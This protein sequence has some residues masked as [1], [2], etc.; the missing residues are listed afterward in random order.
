MRI[1]VVGTGIS[2]N[3]LAHELCREHEVTVFEARDRPGGHTDTWEVELAGR[4]YAVDT[5]FIVFNDRT[6]PG[7]CALLERLGV[8]SRPTTMSFGV[9]CEASGLEYCGSSLGGLFAQPANLLRPRF[10]R[11]LLDILR[12][13]RA[14]SRLLRAEAGG[15]ALAGAPVTAPVLAAGGP[16]L[17]EFLRQGGY[18]AGFAEHYFLPMA[19]AI[20]SA[21]AADIRRMPLGFLLRFFHN[22]GLLGIAGRPQW[23]TVEG[24]SARYLE[25]LI[26]PFRSRLQL[27]APVESVRRLPEGIQVAAR[28][29][30]PAIFDR[31]FLACHGDQA[32]RLL[33]EPNPL[34]HRALG[35]VHY[36]DNEAVLHTDIRLLPRSPRARAAWNCYLPAEPLARVSV[37]YDMNRLQGLDAP[38]TL[39]VSLN[40]TES[41]DPARI[42]LK[43]AYRHP[44]FT[45]ESLAAQAL[46][47]QVNGLDRIY[48][49]GAYWGCGFH[50]DGLASAL[51]ALAHFRR[52]LAAGAEPRPAAAAPEPLR[53]GS[54]R[55][56]GSPGRG[57]ALPGPAGLR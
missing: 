28:G 56:A 14:A 22:H 38:E 54:F 2:G 49:A 16:A 24:G 11:M 48:Y 12:F 46:H 23:R 45:R 8:A 40:R 21:D 39:C 26:A 18:S 42:L 31:V 9:R 27:G 57:V 1:A 34:E 13:N 52:D 29:C 30:A 53:E 47:A 3:V 4:R 17:D 15:S 43:T 37:T 25:R 44:V 7:F 20:W 55:G 36:Q 50:E 51:A 5:G 19:A 10:H 6:Y 33:A 32:L 41:I 35:P